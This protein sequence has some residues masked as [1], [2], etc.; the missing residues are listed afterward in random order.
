MRRENRDG[1][2]KTDELRD[3]QFCVFVTHILPRLSENDRQTRP[4]GARY[5]R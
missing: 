3:M 5:V 4:H 2:E 1:E